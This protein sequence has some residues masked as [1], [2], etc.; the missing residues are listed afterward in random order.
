MLSFDQ[1]DESFKAMQRLA[2]ANW[3]I[4]SQFTVQQ[5]KLM[6]F[7][8]DCG[9]RELALWHHL[10]KP[11]DWFAAQTDI[12]R[13]LAEHF[14]DYSRAVFTDTAQAASE[15]TACIEALA[16][17]WQ[18]TPTDEASREAAVHSASEE[19]ESESSK[20]ARVRRRAA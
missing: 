8:A 11:A 17:P 18:P 13:E 9:E 2:D 4:W 14:G 1:V 10:D 20:S 12:A 6:G 5:T 15:I 16:R 3:R 7:C 19:T